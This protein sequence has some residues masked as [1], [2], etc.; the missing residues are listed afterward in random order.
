MKEGRK[1]FWENDSERKI[2]RAKDNKSDMK[3]GNESTVKRSIE[4]MK[5][6]LCFRI[7]N[8]LGN[9]K[10][11]PCLWQER[12][13]LFRKPAKKEKKEKNCF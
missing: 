11:Q 1:E 6:K 7:T 3:G 12:H 8:K 10:G 9:S 2:P 13:P 5:Q 4:L